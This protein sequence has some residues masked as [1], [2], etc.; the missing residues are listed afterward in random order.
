MTAVTKSSPR[1]CT[2]YVAPSTRTDP[3]PAMRFSSPARPSRSLENTTPRSGQCLRTR[4]AGAPI[5]MSRPCSMIATRSQ[6]RSASSIKCVVRKTV[7]PRLADAVHQVPDG[8]PRL[9]VESRGELVEEHHLGVVDERERDEEPLLLPA[10]E[11]H[12]RGIALFRESELLEQGATVDRARVERRPEIDR[13]PDADT[14]LQL[15]LLELDAD[16]LLQRLGVAGGIEAQH[17][18]AP[19]VGL[20]NAL[21]A[22]HGRGLAGAVGPD[23]PED[24]ALEHLEGD[25]VDRH[26]G[27]VAACAGGPPR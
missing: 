5:S 11:A 7:L 17:R 8:A 22:F 24:L 1:P 23:E 20:A 6:S 26:G 18:G 27:A 19:R 9:R 15:R 2:V 16:A 4:S 14:L 12:E 21:D 10:R 13:F 25:V 3:A